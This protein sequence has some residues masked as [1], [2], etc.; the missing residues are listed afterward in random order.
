MTAL[1]KT[2][3]SSDEWTYIR[4]LQVIGLAQGRRL[5]SQQEIEANVNENQDGERD[6]GVADHVLDTGFEHS[7]RVPRRRHVE[8]LRW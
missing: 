3:K 5:S 4:Y 2:V 8:I 1:K 7:I 6:L